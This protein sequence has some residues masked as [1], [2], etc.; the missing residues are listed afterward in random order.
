M[1][2]AFCVVSLFEVIRDPQAIDNHPISTTPIPLPPP[3]LL[4]S[5]RLGL[6]VLSGPVRRKRLLALRATRRI[7][8][9]EPAPARA[10][11]KIRL[12]VGGNLS[13]CALHS[14]GPFLAPAG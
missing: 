12:H 9:Q 10:T 7:A 6:N 1:I 5:W 3:T 4:G 13:L 8:F 11:F 2:G 14:T